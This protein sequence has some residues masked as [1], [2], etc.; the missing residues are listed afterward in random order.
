[1]NFFLIFGLGMFCGFV[2][3]V[4]AAM[5]K[6]ESDRRAAEKKNRLR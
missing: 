2:L 3:G 5:H 6:E 4:N 1:M